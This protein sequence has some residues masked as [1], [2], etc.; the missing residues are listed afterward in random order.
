MPELS[1]F[2]FGGMMF[3]LWLIAAMLLRL[4]CLMNGTP[5]PRLVGASMLVLI[6]AGVTAAMHTGLSFAMGMTAEGLHMQPGAAGRLMLM[7]GLPVHMLIAATAYRIMLP[8]T[9]GKAMAV[10]VVQAVAM[11]ALVIG[12]D[13]LMMAIV[14]QGW[15][16]VRGMLPL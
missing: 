6:V 16:Q 13:M 4:A 8:T 10:W 9:F 3:S 11:A 12:F 1:L 5:R 7:L 15:S 14:P 2:I